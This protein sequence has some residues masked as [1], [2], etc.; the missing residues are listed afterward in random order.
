MTSTEMIDFFGTGLERSQNGIVIGKQKGNFHLVS[1]NYRQGFKCRIMQGLIC[2]RIKEGSPVQ[3]FSN[4]VDIANTAVED[5]RSLGSKNIAD[6]FYIEIA[7]IISSLVNKPFELP[8]YS[9]KGIVFD[10]LLSFEL[11]HS[12][13]GKNNEA[14]WNSITNSQKPNKRISLCLETYKIYHELIFNKDKNKTAVLVK[15]AEELF[16]K[17]K[18]DSF[19]SGGGGIEG[20]GPD[21]NVTI[22]YR[23]AAILK[24]I[25][26]DGGTMHKWIWG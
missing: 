5:L 23:L 12:L 10:R 24:F 18:N 9:P 4:A 15:Q 14:E 11:T 2:W 8:Q 17:R 26:Y 19:Y 16:L 22:D 21:N 25:S 20:G 1:L 13:H 3:Y 7:S 6:D